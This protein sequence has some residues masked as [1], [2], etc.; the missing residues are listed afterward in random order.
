[1]EK[2]EKLASLNHEKMDQMNE[3]Q[4]KVEWLEKAL[5]KA[6]S[7]ADKNSKMDHDAL[8][9]QLS[10]LRGDMQVVEMERN[11]AFKIASHMKQE[12]VEL[13]SKASEMASSLDKLKQELTVY[14]ERHQKELKSY[15]SLKTRLADTEAKNAMLSEELQQVQVIATQDMAIHMEADFESQKAS[16]LVRINELETDLDACKLTLL[17]KEKELCSLM[18]SLN[19]KMESRDKEVV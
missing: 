10:Q 8:L 12:R 9:S 13:K 17:I 18:E 1:M 6:K 15:E 16:Y 7:V 2:T 4:K 14:E 11:K 3:L 5:V 19:S